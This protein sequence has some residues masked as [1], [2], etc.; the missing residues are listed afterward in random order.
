MNTQ[1]KEIKIVILCS[2][3]IA[4]NVTFG[5]IATS[6]NMPLLYLDAIGTI[7]IAVNFP[8]KYGVLT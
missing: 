7:F 1:Q 3:A 2:I 8:M 4:I 5:A 6:I